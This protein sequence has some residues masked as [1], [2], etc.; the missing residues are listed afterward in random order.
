MA[1]H[2]SLPLTQALVMAARQ[3]ALVGAPIDELLAKVE[4]LGMA[5]NVPAEQAAFLA[6]RQPALLEYGPDQLS[7]ACARL[8]SVL[9]VSQRGMGLL[10]AKLRDQELRLV[11]G[12]SASYLADRLEDIRESVALPLGSTRGMDVLRM[13]VR[14][15]GLLAVSP[16]SLSMSC[17]ALLDAYQAAPGTFVVVLGRCPSL[18]TYPATAIRANLAG[19]LRY[20][21]VSGLA[22]AAA[23]VLVMD[24][25]P[26]SRAHDHCCHWL[27][28]CL[29]ISCLLCH[30]RSYHDACSAC[31]DPLG[32]PH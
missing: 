7:A 23:C 28:L 13:V 9:G 25:S 5:L 12:M 18:L 2:L 8:A 29:E 19:L 4:T 16:A 17:E 24:C 15:P 27:Q 21:A 22:P 31:Q 6:A 3:P 20:L 11:L 26:R 30:M 14:H 1:A 32:L 10:L